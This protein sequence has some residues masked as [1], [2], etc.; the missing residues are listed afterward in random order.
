[1]REVMLIVHFIGLALGLGTSFAFMFL[2]MAGSKMPDEE[3]IQFAFKTAIVSKMGQIGLVLLLLS[4]AHLIH[5]YAADLA[6]MPLLII[7]LVL[8]LA[9]GALI[10]IISSKMKKAQKGDAEKHLKAI[11]TLGKFTML[12]GLTIVGLAVYSFH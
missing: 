1:M 3:R 2:G 4:G 9:L 6:N 12:I 5:P 10:G 7:K 8:F 11:Q